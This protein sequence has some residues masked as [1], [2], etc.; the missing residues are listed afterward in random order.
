MSK[1]KEMKKTRSVTFRV[2]ASLLDALEGA[3]NSLP[4]KPT[5]TAAIE[6]GMELA[7]EEIQRMSLAPRSVE[8]A[9]TITTTSEPQLT[10]AKARQEE[11]SDDGAM[12][13]GTGSWISAA[14]VRLRYNISDMTLYRWS[15]DESLNF[16]RPMKINKRKFFRIE[17][18][19]EWDKRIST[20]SAH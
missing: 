15:T 16:P 4:Y 11:E 13:I 12:N 7:L 20:R 9:E 17:E 3:I 6:R 14:Q 18:L 8:K 5:M 10:S 19:N 1:I 2:H